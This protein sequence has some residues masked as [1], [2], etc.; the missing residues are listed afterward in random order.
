MN[1]R[2]LGMTLVGIMLAIFVTGGS[3]SV[4]AQIGGGGAIEGTITDPG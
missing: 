1:A 4:K 2:F 3:S